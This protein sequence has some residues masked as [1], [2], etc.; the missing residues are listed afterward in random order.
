[1]IKLSANKTKWTV[2]LPWV[3]KVA[4]TF[5]KP[6]Q[7]SG[8]CSIKHLESLLLP[9]ACD[10]NPLQGYPQQLQYVSLHNRHFMSQVRRTRHFARSTR[11]GGEGYWYVYQQC[12]FI[13]QGKEG[14]WSKVSH[15]RKLCTSWARLTPDLQT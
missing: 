13:H 6:V 14:Q 12:P 9:P 10:A 2:G 7:D 4:E 5:K 1:M 15:Q 8:F 11:R 3:R